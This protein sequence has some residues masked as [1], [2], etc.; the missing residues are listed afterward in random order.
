MKWDGVVLSKGAKRCTGKGVSP[1]R[2]EESK[3]SRTRRQGQAAFRM[4]RQL[5][6]ISEGKIPE[7]TRLPR[8]SEKFLSWKAQIR[9]LDKSRSSKYNGTALEGWH[10]IGAGVPNIL[11]NRTGGLVGWP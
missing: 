4:E 8:V 6:N 7:K 11:L 3:V 10:R 1:S 9:G 5:R 2:A